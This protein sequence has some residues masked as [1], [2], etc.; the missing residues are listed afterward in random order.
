[1]MMIVKR[2][3]ANIVDIIV[4]FALV[5][6]SYLY[7]FPIISRWLENYTVIAVILLI[8]VVAVNTALQVP[9]MMVHQT[10]GKAFF[11]LEI[12]STNDQRPISPSIVL[13]R[14]LF[15]KVATG[16]LLCLP[17]LFGKTGGHEVVSE[18]KVI[19]K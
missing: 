8:L 14:E 3:L 16:Y 19:S 17:V 9:F 18:T 4:F 11:G 13:Q 7:L 2:L 12:E 15:G 1:M 5:T 6:I 10:L